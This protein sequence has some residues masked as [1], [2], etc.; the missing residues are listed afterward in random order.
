MTQ[1]YEPGHEGYR[2][3]PIIAG[4]ED[5]EMQALGQCMLAQSLITTYELRGN[6]VPAIHGTVQAIGSKAPAVIIRDIFM[7]HGHVS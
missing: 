2:E 7:K 3:R 6:Q 4:V 1:H 5:T